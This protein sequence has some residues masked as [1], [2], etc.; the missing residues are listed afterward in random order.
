MQQ[1]LILWMQM[2]H[3][4]CSFENI[5]IIFAM[6]I[7]FCIIMQHIK[8]RPILTFRFSR[9]RTFFSTDWTARLNPDSLDDPTT[10]TEVMLEAE[11]KLEE[12]LETRDAE[13]IV[14]IEMMMMSQQ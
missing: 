5:F 8:K 2:L 14:A 13:G 12:L 6:C 3:K 7:V 11:V 4:T 9:F 1:I 10:S